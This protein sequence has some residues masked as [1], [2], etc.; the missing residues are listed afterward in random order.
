M[1]PEK[2]TPLHT[3]KIIVPHPP[4]DDMVLV[5]DGDDDDLP[6]QITEAVA[7]RLIAIHDGLQGHTAPHSST[8]IG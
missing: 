3:V 4:N 8:D 6:Y 7:L 5:T 1:K 2:D